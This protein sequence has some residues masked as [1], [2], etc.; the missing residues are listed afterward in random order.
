M[1]QLLIC[2]NAMCLQR[3]KTPYPLPHPISASNLGG[4]IETITYLPPRKGILIS[5]QLR[6]ANQYSLALA[7]ERVGIIN[8]GESS[9][10]TAAHTSKRYLVSFRL[11][12]VIWILT[13]NVLL[14]GC[15]S[16]L[17]H[18][19]FQSNHEPRWILAAVYT[20]VNSSLYKIAAQILT[21]LFCLLLLVK[22]VGSM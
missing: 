5:L 21:D 22:T 12:V 18:S 3:F 10:L 1:Q 9:P 2:V 7:L 16:H 14:T 20:S 11:G 17:Y 15:I 13:S 8:P 6:A 4:D 19:C